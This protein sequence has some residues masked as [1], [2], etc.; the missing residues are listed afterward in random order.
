MA[1]LQCV[2][3]T[4]G[5]VVALAHKDEAGVSNSRAAYFV[6]FILVPKTIWTKGPT[7]LYKIKDLFIYICLILF[8]VLLV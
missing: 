1:I 4:D 2:I 7:Y 5:I 6:N 8:N 3:V